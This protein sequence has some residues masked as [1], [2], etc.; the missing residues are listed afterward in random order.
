MDDRDR[1]HLLDLMSHA[2][3]AIGYADAH[4]AG[5]WRNPET[6]DAVLMRLAQVGEAA[7]RTSP[8]GLAEITGVS[9]SDVKGIRARIVH[10][11]DQIDVNIIR[12]VVSRQLPRLVE[13]VGKGLGLPHAG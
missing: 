12:G 7:R 1:R 3:A 13:V 2:T 9:W 8:D 5:W 4:G 6:L 11:Y 10:D